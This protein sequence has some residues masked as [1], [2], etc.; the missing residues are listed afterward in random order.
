LR[1]EEFFPNHLQRV[2]AALHRRRPLIR[3]SC[4]RQKGETYGLEH[5][6]RDRNRRWHGN[7]LLRLRRYLIDTQ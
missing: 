7:Q 2:P 3:F 5:T 6:A 1:A 4:F